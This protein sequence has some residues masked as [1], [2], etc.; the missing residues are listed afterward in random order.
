MANIASKASDIRTKVYGKDVR[1]SLASGIEAIN[2][3][4]VSTTAKENVLQSQFNGLIINAGSSNAE[5]VAA[6]TS[7]ITGLTSDTVGHRID[8]IDSSLE[9]IV[10]KRIRIDVMNPPVSTGLLPLTGSNTVQDTIR[11]QAIFDWVQAN[12]VSYAGGG[13]YSGYSYKVDFGTASYIFD[14]KINLK[15]SYLNLVADRAIIQ[16]THNDFPFE[17]TASYGWQT[18]MRGF[19]FDR[20]H[21]GLNIANDNIEGGT[22]EITDCWFFYTTDTAIKLNKISSIA[23]IHHNRFIGCKH[24]LENINCDKAYLEHNWISDMS[25]SV[26]QDAPIINRGRLYVKDNLFV[27][28]EIIGGA[29]EN[30]Y[31]NNY[32]LDGITNTLVVEDNHFGGE[33]GQKSIVNNFVTGNTGSPMTPTIVVVKNNDECYTA[34]QPIVRL[35]QVPNKLEI[36]G[37]SGLQY[38]ALSMEWGIGVVVSNV[39]AIYNN[40]TRR[41][42]IIVNNNVGQ[43]PSY[44][45]NILADLIQ[46]A[47]DG[48]YFPNIITPTLLGSWS[49]YDVA[50]S[51]AQY[52][53]DKSGMVHLKGFVKGG[54]GNIFT[55]PTGYRPL[56]QENFIVMSNGTVGYIVI[57]T[58]GNVGLAGGSNVNVSLSQI[59]FMCGI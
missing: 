56:L 26:N 55:L 40:I 15:G 28:A 44:C 10:H 2:D 39:I 54:S 22:T 46:F 20:T 51:N 59:S 9:D 33:I 21:G 4:V 29:T 37:N 41:C 49:N 30:A 14:T 16:T 50:N 57:S 52:W 43:E 48:S 6:H 7:T 38:P 19:T 18:K 53:K 27:P 23:D 13:L 45:N 24:V 25:R 34:D 11:L 31:I 42:K 17:T 32:S 47:D 3:E 58:I 36:T 5:I 8:G 12:S 1:E 35:F